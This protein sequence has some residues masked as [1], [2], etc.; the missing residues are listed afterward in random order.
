MKRIGVIALCRR[1]G[2]AMTDDEVLRAVL[3]VIRPLHDEVM[4]RLVARW[5]EAGVVTA[6]DVTHI[7]ATTGTPEYQP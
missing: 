2:A 5:C 1:K 3:N 6:T 7:V 4:A